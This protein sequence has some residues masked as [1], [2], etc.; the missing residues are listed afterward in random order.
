MAIDM[1]YFVLTPIILTVLWK[2]PKIGQGLIGLLIAGLSLPVL[3]VGVASLTLS[4]PGHFGCHLQ[5]FSTASTFCTEPS[6]SSTTAGSRLWLGT[7]I[8]C[9]RSSLSVSCQ[10][11]HLLPS[12]W[13]SCLRHPLYN[14]RK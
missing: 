8:L 12:S 10:F 4:Y 7:V 1:Q 6:S 3:K 14:W 5:D 2:A 11:Q 9:W 13:W